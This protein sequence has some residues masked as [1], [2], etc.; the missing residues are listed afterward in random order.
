MV[1][2]EKKESSEVASKLRD[3]ETTGHEANLAGELSERAR[4]LI[5]AQPMN[6]FAPLRYMVLLRSAENGN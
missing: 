2:E 1:K 3:T 4:E 5:K 6:P